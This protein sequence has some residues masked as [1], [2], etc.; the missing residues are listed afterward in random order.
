M[1]NE[2]A[3]PSPSPTSASDASTSEKAELR[4]LMEGAVRAIRALVVGIIKTI[5][6]AIPW[7]IRVVSAG[8]WGYGMMQAALAVVE[9]YGKQ[10]TE[11]IPLYALVAVPV[12]VGFAAP[13]FWVAEQ[14][15]QNIWGAFLI[16]GAFLWAAAD[17]LRQ[18]WRLHPL[19]TALAPTA[20]AVFA[21]THLVLGWRFSRRQIR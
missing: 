12:V 19:I 2:V 5:L 16:T 20:L 4:A 6:R 21:H 13:T 9:V 18:N 1:E 8:T 14:Q 7:L 17:L 3:S 15:R 11:K 10:T